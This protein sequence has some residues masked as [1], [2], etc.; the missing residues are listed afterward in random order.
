MR[1]ATWALV[2]IFLSACPADLSAQDVPIEQ[3]PE[4][5]A[6]AASSSP[7][8]TLRNPANRLEPGKKPDAGPSILTLVGSLALVLGVFL[9]LAWAFRRMMPPG[10]GPLPPEVFEVL[11][12]APLANRQQAHLLRCGNKLLLVSAG[13][14]GVSPLAEITDTAEVDRL[15]NLCQQSRPAAATALRRALCQ[16]GES[17]D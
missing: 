2:L 6:K 7:A 4:A 13:A 16:K 11:G 9:G 8:I 12:R 3:R 10:A 1:S 5:P 17:H 15:T 14:A